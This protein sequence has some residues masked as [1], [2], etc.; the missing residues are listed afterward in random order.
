MVE[1]A[2]TALQKCP[3]SPAQRRL[4]GRCGLPKARSACPETVKRVQVGG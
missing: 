1:L 3:R 2:S 4:E